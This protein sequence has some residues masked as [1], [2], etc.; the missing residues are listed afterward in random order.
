MSGPGGGQVLSWLKV[1]EVL[2]I[3]DYGEWMF[4]TVFEMTP[5]L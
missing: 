1:S 3:A 4:S 5:L 2:M